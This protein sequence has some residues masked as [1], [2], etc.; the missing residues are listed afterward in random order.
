MFIKLLYIQIHCTRAGIDA[1]VRRTDLDQQA[2]HLLV[3]FE[4]LEA[5]LRIILSETEITLSK[6]E[7]LLISKSDPLDF[8]EADEAVSIINSQFSCCTY[9]VIYKTRVPYRTRVISHVKRDT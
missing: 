8:A 1:K 3:I 4:N 5:T 9:F 2:R 6:T 7:P